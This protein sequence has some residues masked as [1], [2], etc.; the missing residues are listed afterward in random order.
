ME[1]WTDV[2]GQRI[3]SLEG[4]IADIIKRVFRPFRRTL[5]RASELLAE[6][7]PRRLTMPYEAVGILRDA[8]RGLDPFGQ[9]GALDVGSGFASLG[10]SEL[11][12]ALRSMQAT[13]LD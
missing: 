13:R 9:T 12:I 11:E 3:G 8:S 4:T 5:G 2:G 6:P 7:S 10:A 1:T